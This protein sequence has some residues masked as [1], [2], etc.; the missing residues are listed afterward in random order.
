M[1]RTILFSILVIVTS[2]FL[3]SCSEEEN[4]PLT[5]DF[6]AE[7]NGKAPNAEVTFSNKSTGADSYEWT[8]GVGASNRASLKKEPEAIT[9]DK[10]GE[11]SVKLV[12]SNGSD[13]KVLTDTVNIEGNSAIVSYKDIE[14][15]VEAGGDYGRF[16]SF[17]AEEIYKKGEITTGGSKIDI[18]FESMGGTMYYFNSPADDAYDFPNATKTEII[19]YQSEP[20]I[21]VDQFDSMEDD[22]LLEGLTI[23]D[24]DDSFGN[25]TIPNTVLFE[26]SE[27]KKGVIKTKKVNSERLLVDINIQKYSDKQ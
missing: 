6:E 17:K 12:V 25:S 8:F 26:L 24:D 15:G 14:F 9:V 23:K 10:A 4:E 21:T 1:K 11:L 3:F 22:E 7:V 2:I 20:S 5:V 13:E 16:Y 18:A 19:N 27:G